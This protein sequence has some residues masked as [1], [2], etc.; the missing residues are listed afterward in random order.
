MAVANDADVAE[1]VRTASMRTKK[2]RV[3]IEIY[4]DGGVLMLGPTTSAGAMVLGAE[5]SGGAEDVGAVVMEQ[6]KLELELRMLEPEAPLYALL[7]V[8]APLQEG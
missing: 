1:N 7:E 6:W 8:A 2:S 4:C 3:D 5:G